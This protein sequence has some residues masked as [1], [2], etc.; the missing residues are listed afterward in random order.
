MFLRWFQS[1]LRCCSSFR[2]PRIPPREARRVFSQIKTWGPRRAHDGLGVLW[3]AGGPPG[4][5]GSVFW[6]L[7][8]CSLCSVLSSYSLHWGSEPRG[9]AFLA[10]ALAP[11]STAFYSVFFFFFSFLISCRFLRT[12]QEYKNRIEW[13]GNTMCHSRVGLSG[14]KIVVSWFCFSE[15]DT[16]ETLKTE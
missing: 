16:G 12:F 2:C 8:L 11:L 7:D 9:A 6:L 1:T 13:K 14:R 3:L 4:L 15:I 5:W 10:T